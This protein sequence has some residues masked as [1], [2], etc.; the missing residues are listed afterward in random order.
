[1]VE[2]IKTAATEGLFNTVLAEFNIG[3]IAEEDL[4]R[5]IRLFGTEVLPAL[6]SFAPY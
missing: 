2:R 5:S 4:M 3:D 1:V 6:R